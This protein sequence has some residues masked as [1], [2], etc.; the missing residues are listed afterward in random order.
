MA[1]FD[2]VRRTVSTVASGFVDLAAM[3]VAPDGTFVTLDAARNELSQYTADG[4]LHDRFI[5]LVKPKSLTFDST[6]R[7]LVANSAPDGVALVRPDGRLTALA[8]VPGVQ[9]LYAER[10]GRFTLSRG[11]TV[12][13]V[14]PAVETRSS[15]GTLLNSLASKS[16]TG[17][18]RTAQGTL[19]VVDNSV[20]VAYAA[21]GTAQTLASGLVKQVDVQ[22]NAAGVIHVLDESRGVIVA[23]TAPNTTRLIAAGLPQATAMAFDHDT[24]Y[25]AYGSRQ[26]AAFDVH[27]QRTEL[28]I[29]VTLPG[30]I[31][32]LIV[33]GGTGVATV[34]DTNGVYRLHLPATADE[35]LQ[36]GDIVYTITQPVP[37]LL[38]GTAAVTVDLG[39]FTPPVSG[40]FQVDVVATDAA[41]TGHLSNTLHVGAQASGT[42]ALAQARVAPGER[43]VAAQ[44][45]LTG[46]DTTSIARVEPQGA[47]L[48]G[49]SRAFGRAL[50]S[51]SHGNIYVADTT[52]LVK[53]TPTGQMST[54]VAG[55]Q[56]GYGLAVDNQDRLYA[57]SGPR[58]LQITVPDAQV[59]TVATLGGTVTAVATDVQGVLYAVDSTGTLSR[60]EADGRVTPVASLGS[61]ANPQGLTID[62]FGTFYILF[63]NSHIVR[64]SPDGKTHSDYFSA[65]RFEFEGVNVVADCANNLLFAPLV[66]PPSKLSGEED[67]IFQ[68][69]GATGE[70]R[71]VLYG[72][73]LHRTLNDIDVLFYDRFHQRLLSWDDTGQVFTLPVSCGALEVEAHLVTRSDVSLLNAMP[74]PTRLLPRPD[75]TQ[76]AVWVLSQVDNRGENIQLNFQFHAL[77]EGEQRAAVA[78]AFL[79]FHNSFAPAETVR[80]PLGIPTVEASSA[81]ELMVHLPQPAYGPDETVAITTTVFNR[82]DTAFTGRL[83]LTIVDGA[84]VL[85]ATLADVP[86]QGLAGRAAQ[87]IASQWETGRTLAGP[88]RVEVQLFDTAGRQVA[89]GEVSFTL[90]TALPGSPV[91]T[92]TVTPEQR[93]YAAWDTGVLHIRVRNTSLNVLQPPSLVTVTLSAPS[94]S[95]L[96]HTTQ[97]L[98]ALL[99]ESLQDLNLPFALVDQ[100]SG[101]YPIAVTVTDLSSGALLAMAST[102]VQ[103]ERTATQGLLGSVYVDHTQVQVGQANACTA[104]L[105]NRAAATSPA[106]TLTARLVL[107]TDAGA[108]L[109]EQPAER[110]LAGGATVTSTMS[111]QTA[112]LQPGAYVCV[113]QRNTGADWVTLAF[114][115]FT[116]VQALNQAPIA[117]AGPDR[118][119]FVGDTVTLDGA[120]SQ[121]PDGDRLTYAWSLR[122]VPPGSTATLLAP[123]T[124]TP[125]LTLDRTGRYEIHLLV[126]DGHLDSLPAL[127]TLTVP[128]RPPVADAG[129]GQHAVTGQPVTLNG[130]QSADPDGDLLTYAWSLQ[131]QTDAI[132]ATSTLTDAAIAG[133]TTPAPQF[134]PDVDGAYV[135]ELRVH[136]GQVASMPVYVTVTASTPNV[137]PNARAGADHTAIVG[138]LVALDGR[139]STD[140]DHGPQ[141]LTFRWTFATVPPG[142]LLQDASIRTADQA[143]AS[144]V[145]DAPGLYALTL[146]VSDGQDSADDTLLITVARDTPPNARAGSDQTVTLGAEV[147]LDGTASDDPDQGPQPLTFQWRVISVPSGSQLTSAALRA[148]QTPTP[149]FTPD[150]QGEYVLGL[151]VFDGAERA[152]DHVLVTVQVAIVNQPPVANAGPAQTVDPGQVV[153]LDGRASSDPEGDTLTWQW[154]QIGGPPVPVQASQSPTP[155]FTAPSFT[156]GMLPLVFQL[157]VSDGRLSSAPATVSITVRPPAPTLVCTQAQAAP[158]RLWPPNHKLVAVAITGIRDAQGAL[159]DPVRDPLTVT[160]TTV[161]Q[162]EPINGLGDGDT[163]PDAVLQGPTVLVRA[164]RAGGGN[165]RVYQLQFTA[166]TGRPAGHCTGTVLVCVPPNSQG[167]CIQDGPRY[168]STRP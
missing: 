119:A 61:A 113:L 54:F 103:V 37:A 75:G 96:L 65:A 85:V 27:G 166:D 2:P 73:A 132:P 160:I 41:I 42:L 14:F 128:N 94:N 84:G 18:G 16:P 109:A 52:R 108:V 145:S 140:P 51:D 168:D 81:M 20:L 60:L 137:P 101:A 7:L 23:L 126:N 104:T 134:T 48:L 68:L 105:T 93:L 43:T 22:T 34:E 97:T 25:V 29:A 129:R 1:R 152:T 87:P 138:A 63:N 36:P 86:L 144:F 32:G 148:A 8:S 100:A 28:Q 143:Q 83:A 4:T 112:G 5:G 12:S 156:A 30:A 31:H 115:P 13:G 139:A 130:S 124:R 46:A 127:V 89:T 74:A 120:G 107:L 123:T 163:S 15:T 161:Q 95:V 9:Y 62:A 106:V 150:V 147:G 154:T 49:N 149:R 6:G 3:A 90:G 114:A 66:L 151:D 45:R 110:T 10:D 71:Q 35:A 38:P 67:M 111:V 157:V 118:T 55:I 59:R 47:V 57:V 122:S 155:T 72:P 116:L 26:L 167:T 39:S 142:S 88:Y 131:W 19:L 76:E 146:H 117:N 53:M 98:G 164:E 77:Q 99:P 102:T 91:L 33:Q 121:D 162:D 165:G 70:V 40:D 56:V 64:V 92:V 50:A 79:T 78:D 17:L 153:T 80:A 82:N 158:A 141:P 136:D 125:S 159:V 44:L 58:V 69:V 133:R 24:L 11:F 135:V 21:D